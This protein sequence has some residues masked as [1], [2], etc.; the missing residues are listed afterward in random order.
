M[1]FQSY[2][3]LFQ[4]LLNSCLGIFWLCL[5]ILGSETLHKHVFK[6]IFSTLWKTQI[7]KH[8]YKCCTIKYSMRGGVKWHITQGKAKCCIFHETP[9][10]VLYFI[11]QHE[12]TVLLL[13]CWFW[14]G[15]LISL[16]WTWVWERGFTKM[17]N[18]LPGP[19]ISLLL[20]PK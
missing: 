16:L 12:Y 17:L 20:L 1:K 19:V 11:V 7:L 3:Y 13:I 14:N 10:Q 8:H 9:P 4:T 5:T 15:G 18:K 2:F 6:M